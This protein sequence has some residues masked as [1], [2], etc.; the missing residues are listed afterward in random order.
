MTE[1]IPAID[2]WAPLRRFGQATIQDKILY[3]SGAFLL[4]RAPAELLA[5]F[6]ALPIKPEVM[7]KWLWKNA[8]VLLQLA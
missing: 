3:G 8:A 7:E 2:M 4:G 5:E 1:T 6:R